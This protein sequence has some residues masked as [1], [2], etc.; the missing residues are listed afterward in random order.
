[1]GK[2]FGTDEDE[3][4]DEERDDEGQGDDEGLPKDGS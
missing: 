2:K 4:F 1:M 3:V